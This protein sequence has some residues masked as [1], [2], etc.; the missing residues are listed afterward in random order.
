MTLKMLE[1]FKIDDFNYN[2]HKIAI[3]LEAAERK[4]DEDDEV[5]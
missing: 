1:K 3:F 4:E 2:F 5:Q